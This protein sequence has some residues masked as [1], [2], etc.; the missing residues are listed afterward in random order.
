MSVA[1]GWQLELLN[2][3]NKLFGFH[4]LCILKF[5]I[6]YNLILLFDLKNSAQK[7][8][9]K[10]IVEND[11]ILKDT[12][13]PIKTARNDSIWGAIG[14]S[15]KKAIID[16]Y[17]FPQCLSYLRGFEEG[18]SSFAKEWGSSG[19]KKTGKNNNAIKYK[20]ELK[21]VGEDDRLFSSN[22]DYVFDVY[23]AKGLH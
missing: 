8:I 5:A 11:Y 3:L 22:N 19:I 15:A 16:K 18:L 2:T 1:I 6:F 9:L 7:S 10:Q 14:V 13:I 20:M 21:L 12:K 17:K 4:L 23:S